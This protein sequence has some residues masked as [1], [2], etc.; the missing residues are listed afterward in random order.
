ML[1]CGVVA[2]HIVYACPNTIYSM[3]GFKV[4]GCLYYMCV[5]LEYAVNP[6]VK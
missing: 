1:W 3:G 6:K 2:L 5:L 4:G